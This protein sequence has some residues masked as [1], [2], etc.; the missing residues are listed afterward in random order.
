MN[1]KHTL[2]YL[3]KRP[4]R[5]ER[6]KILIVT[7]GEK[8]EY[9]YFNDLKRIERLTNVS[10]S[11]KPKPK[12]PKK[13]I[14]AI[15]KMNDIDSYDR[16]WCVF[17][18]DEFTE[19]NIEKAISEAG[20]KKIKIVYS[21]QCFE[22][23]YLLHYHF[24]NTAILRKQYFSKL[25]KLLGNEY[26]KNAEDLYEKLSSKQPTAI[27]NAKRLLS[28]YASDSPF[29]NNPSTTVHILVEGLKKY[30]P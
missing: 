8:T 11:I 6:L 14:Q 17:D 22:L 3:K 2:P 26:E 10:V 9:N 7:Q 15:C 19:K 16:I 25:S 21:N 23:W 30:S 20:E 27:K 1:K 13:M 18:I 5:N 29:K 4:E 12:D 28:K 24:F